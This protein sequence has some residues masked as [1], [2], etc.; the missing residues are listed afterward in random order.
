MLLAHA[1]VFGEF[2]Q[3]ERIGKVLGL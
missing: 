1:V 3:K 2:V